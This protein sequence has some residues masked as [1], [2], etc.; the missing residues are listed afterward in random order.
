MLIMVHIREHSF[1]LKLTKNLHESSQDTGTT[2]NECLAPRK[3]AVPELPTCG[4]SILT[5]ISTFPRNPRFVLLWSTALV[6]YSL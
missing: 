1:N 2:N 4:I 6:A 3:I 5:T